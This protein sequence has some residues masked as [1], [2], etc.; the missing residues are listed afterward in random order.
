MPDFD[1][2]RII[3]AYLHQQGETQPIQ[4]Q[5][6]YPDHVTVILGDFRKLTIP[7]SAL[8]TLHAIQ[9]AAEQVQKTA[10]GVAAAAGAVADTLE[11]LLDEVTPDADPEPTTINDGAE[12]QNPSVLSPYVATPPPNNQPPAASSQPL[13]VTTTKKKK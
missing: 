4:D 10:E 7:K 9:Q 3:P 1:L 12:E 8:T 13:T 2:L 6:E 11:T 5:K